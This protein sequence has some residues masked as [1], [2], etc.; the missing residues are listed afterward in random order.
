[1]QTT[2][3]ARHLVATGALALGAVS[4]AEA[5]DWVAAWSS[6]MQ[7]ASPETWSM[8]DA[9]IRLIARTTVAGDQVRIRLENTFGEAPLDIGAATIGLQASGPAL[10]PNSV[11]PI[12]FSASPSVTIPPGGLVVSDPLALPVEAEQ[13]LA[14]S[15]HVRGTDV[16][17]SQHSNGLTTSYVTEPGTGDLT[18]AVDRDPFLDTTNS[19][20][21]LSAI[22]VHSSSARGAIVAFGDSITDGSCATV[23]GYDRWA[24]V[25][26]ARLRER[27]GGARLA[28]VNAGIGGNTVI[29]VPPV[30]SPPGLERF[31]RDALDLAGVTHVVLFLGTNDLRRDAEADQVI[32]GLDTLMQRAK[33]RGLTVLASTIIPRNPVPRGLPAN[34][35]FTPARNAARHQINDWIRNNDDLDGVLDFDA[36]MQADGDNDLVEPIYDCDGI[37]PNVL[38]YAAMARSI[39]LDLFT[40]A[41]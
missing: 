37:H 34:L 6:S 31:D 32:A 7:S 18:T 9:T 22:E 27:D 3:F 5:Q 14:I 33:D 16:R 19:I 2:S 10:V 35:G 23:D 20:H 12:R 41:P 8:T 26:Y 4:S 1:M 40:A 17:S 28:M 11:R 21:W 24:D 38:G 13:R 39:D 25:L 15:L 29:R 36:V 30:G